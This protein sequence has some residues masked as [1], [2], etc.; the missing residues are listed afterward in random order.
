MLLAMLSLGLGG[1][2]GG[3]EEE[4][5]ATA[6]AGQ[7]APGQESTEPATIRAN[8]PPEARLEVIRVEGYAG[9]TRFRPR[10]G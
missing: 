1:G 9:M 5:S 4:Q 8:R 3:I 2:C 7:A 6:D 10:K